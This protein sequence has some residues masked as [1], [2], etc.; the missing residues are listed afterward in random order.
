M[1]IMGDNALHV[2]EFGR[3]S[4]RT[5]SLRWYYQVVGYEDLILVCHEFDYREWDGRHGIALVNAETVDG[6]IICQQFPK[7][8]AR[9]NGRRDLVQITV[10]TDARTTRGEKLR[11]SEAV[12]HFLGPPTV[13]TIED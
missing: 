3:R 8:P 1:K 13:G 7:A 10:R 4:P 9:W 12:A 6:S 2:A 5:D 11:L